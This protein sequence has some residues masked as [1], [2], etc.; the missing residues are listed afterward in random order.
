MTA[1]IYVS[2]RIKRARDHLA[3]RRSITIRQHLYHNLTPN[4]FALSRYKFTRQV[5]FTTYSTLIPLPQDPWIYQ[6]TAM[7]LMILRALLAT[8][9]VVPQV[10]GHSI[11]SFPSHPDFTTHDSLPANHT[12][13]QLPHS[14]LKSV[15][16]RGQALGVYEC[17]GSPWIPPCTWTRA[18]G[19]QCHDVKYA[20][21][22]SIGP[23]Q[24][25]ACTVYGAGQCLLTSE[26]SDGFVWPGIATFDTSQWWQTLLTGNDKNAKLLSYKCWIQ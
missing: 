14:F 15:T 8:A 13:V 21:N 24:G 4:Y 25:L 23:D 18:D 3:C 9:V 6:H 12:N 10:V 1:M 5:L 2:S 19:K 11:P 7:H 20:K 16:R 22:F 17:A 26:I